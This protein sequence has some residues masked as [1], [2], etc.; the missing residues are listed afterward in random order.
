MELFWRPQATQIVQDAARLAAR[1]GHA[2]VAPVHVLSELRARSESDFG[3]FVLAAFG[4][5]KQILRDATRQWRLQEPV[6][7]DSAELPVNLGLPIT[8]SL[9]A[10]LRPAN[11]L[12][13]SRDFGAVDTQSLVYFLL[14]DA[15]SPG[16]RLLRS[17]SVDA[18]ALC[19]EINVED[20]QAILRHGTP[21]LS[22]Y[23]ERRQASLGGRLRR[24]INWFR[25][26]IRTLPY[27]P[28]EAR[29]MV[30]DLIDEA[31]Q[32]DGD[33]FVLRESDLVD[34]LPTATTRRKRFDAPTAFRE[35]CRYLTAD[36]RGIL[37]YGSG[38]RSRVPFTRQLARVRLRCLDG[39]ITITVTERQ[40]VPVRPAQDLP[41]DLAM[42]VTA[43]CRREGRLW[44]TV[45]RESFLRRLRSETRAHPGFD[46][47][48][49]YD[50]LLAELNAAP[51]HEGMD[52]RP[53]NYGGG[54]YLYAEGDLVR[55][56]RWL[57]PW[58]RGRIRSR[59][60]IGNA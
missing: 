32:R 14:R 9:Q 20:V 44:A 15:E 45:T 13:R 23:M 18:T 19:A 5:S 47:A 33:S 28:L 30:K 58:T 42:D 56:A 53:Y 21:V 16:A 4:V 52:Y 48:K 8:E 59:M 37:S 36:P 3:A 38:S 40:T 11:E 25:P 39:A 50:A 12:S 31:R 49:A 41:I 22:A 26:A 29:C 7:H 27:R 35:I 57:P 60:I 43:A 17:V 6:V 46:E 34:W 2:A 1:A 51:S 54:G 10:A 24:L 55:Y